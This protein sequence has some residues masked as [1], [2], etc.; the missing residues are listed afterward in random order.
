MTPDRNIKTQENPIFTVFGG[1]LKKIKGHFELYTVISMTANCNKMHAK[2]Y[3][4]P[5]DQ[6]CVH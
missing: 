5:S 4:M 3:I 6:N 1:I 2:L